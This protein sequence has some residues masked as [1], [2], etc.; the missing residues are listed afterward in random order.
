MLLV[1]ALGPL[2]KPHLALSARVVVLA[3]ES[4]SRPQEVMAVYL[5]RQCHQQS[6][7]HSSKGWIPWVAGPPSWRHH[8]DV[9][10]QWLESEGERSHRS[11]QTAR[12]LS[13]MNPLSH[14]L[15]L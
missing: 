6:S 15:H 11:A 10:G 12:K 8:H 14:I 5:A 4:A 1:L 13:L 2:S 3:L 9:I 7:T